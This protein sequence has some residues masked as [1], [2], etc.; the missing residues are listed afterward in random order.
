MIE[1]FMKSTI[2]I[3]EV[4]QKIRMLMKDIA[5]LDKANSCH[6][7]DEL[8][9]K[10]KQLAEI[11]VCVHRLLE[12]E[13]NTPNKEGCISIHDL[14]SLSTHENTN[15]VY[16]LRSAAIRVNNIE[17]ALFLFD[18]YGP[19]DLTLIQEAIDYN[20]L[21]CLY[22]IMRTQIAKKILTDK[23]LEN[24]LEFIINYKNTSVVAD[25]IMVEF[26]T[27]ISER[28]LLKQDHITGNT[29]L[30]NYLKNGLSESKEHRRPRLFRQAPT[31]I[32]EPESVGDKKNSL[33]HR[34]PY[35]RNNSHE[36]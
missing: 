17:Y 13:H 31:P 26:P 8:N 7:I 3:S 15:I 20:R 6:H 21:D 16:E 4:D 11:I 30:F 36:I 12:I 33:T 28:F 19:I 10:I 27:H 29:E 18:G 5:K 9:A 24:I 22:K 1:S 35:N 32:S 14:L 2:N 25:A 23:K 34:R